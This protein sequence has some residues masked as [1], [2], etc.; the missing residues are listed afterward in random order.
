MW[1]CSCLTKTM[2]MNNGKSIINNLSYFVFGVFFACLVIHGNKTETV[3]T[4]RVTDTL[5]L[6][7]TDT[8]FYEKPVYKTRTVIDTVFIACDNDVEIPIQI[9][10]KH[11]SKEGVYDAWVSG[12]NPEL[13]S[14]SVYNKTEYQII[15]NEVETVRESNRIGVYANAG[16]V[17][18]DGHNGGHVGISIATRKKLSFGVKAGVINKKPFYGATVGYKIN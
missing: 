8:L 18:F 13:D 7:K 1:Q 10:Q 15:T 9:E 14:I 6:F 11:Y 3:K 5:Y 2:K 17:A 4:E 12:Y 16:F